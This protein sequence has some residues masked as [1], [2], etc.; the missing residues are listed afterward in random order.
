MA[1]AQ[2]SGEIWQT[3]GAVRTEF[4]RYND[5]VDLVAKQLQTV[6]GSVQK[7]GTRTRAM[8]RALKNVETM[9]DEAAAAKLLGLDIAVAD[10]EADA[11]LEAAADN[12]AQLA[13]RIAS[14]S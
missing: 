1:I 14:V 9:P 2:R 4:R 6:S 8:D 13:G 10:L 3:L 5:A 12:I 11:E 7:L